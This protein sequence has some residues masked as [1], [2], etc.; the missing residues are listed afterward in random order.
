MAQVQITSHISSKFNEELRDTHGRALEMGR[1]VERQLEAALNAIA[2]D[3]GGMARGVIDRDRR[4][5]E[6]EL[7]IDEDCIRIIAQRQPAAGDLR[8]IIAVMRMIIDLERMGDEARR[9]AYMAAHLAKRAGTN[10]QYRELRHLG[11]H[12]RAMLRNSLQ[13]F[14]AGDVDLAVDVLHE[15]KKVDREYESIL[16]ETITFMM[17]DPRAIPRAL[18][19]INSARS[20][21]R[22][23]D[24]ACNIAEYAIYYVKGEDIRHSSPDE[25]KEL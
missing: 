23:G 8:F 24:R 14:T 25:L 9:I 11:A 19:I 3:D 16:R 6:M 15:D 13:A 21:E 20:L 1:L 5:N 4:V 2:G 22:I 18:D 7:A 10:V 12:V 17:E